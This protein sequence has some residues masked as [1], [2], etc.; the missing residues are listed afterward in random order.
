[1][2]D[3]PSFAA[4]VA[5]LRHQRRMRTV[6]FIV[7][8]T[9]AIAVMVASARFALENLAPAFRVIPVIAATVAV[10]L[11]IVFFGNHK[12]RNRRRLDGANKAAD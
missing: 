10:I 4:G 7:S 3:K 6:R 12:R 1:M 11:P 8:E 2:T 9:I 5:L